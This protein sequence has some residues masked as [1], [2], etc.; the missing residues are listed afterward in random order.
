MNPAF[1]TLRYVKEVQEMV[2]ASP[3]IF[4]TPGGLQRKA[5][6]VVVAALLATEERVPAPHPSQDLEPEGEGG[7]VPYPPQRDK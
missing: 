1:S 2:A 7:S 6:E 5:A 3:D 4:T